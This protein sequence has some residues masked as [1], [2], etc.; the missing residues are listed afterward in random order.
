MGYWIDLNDSYV[1]CTKSYIESVWW[2]LKQF[3]DKDLIYKGFKVVPYCPRCGSPLSSHEV[4]LG[5]EVVNDPSIYVKFKLSEEEDAFLVAW[6][7]T[8]WTLISNVALAVGAEVDYVRVRYDGEELIVAEGRLEAV[9]DDCEVV[10][11]CFR[12]KADIR[13]SICLSKL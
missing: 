13:K 8:P 7:T 9:L 4:A 2:I 11:R 12:S 5:Y 1:T 3:Y 6:T 10:E